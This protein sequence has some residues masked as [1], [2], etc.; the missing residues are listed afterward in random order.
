M[1]F[2]VPEQDVHRS[3]GKVWYLPHHPVI[4]PKKEKIRIVFDCAAEYGGVS[5]NS[6]V[7]QGPDLTNKLV[8]VLTRFRLN[9]IAVYG[10]YSSNVSSGTSHLR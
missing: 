6:R 9:P 10:G 8:G 1:L 4:N 2:P 5:L 3:D 7:R